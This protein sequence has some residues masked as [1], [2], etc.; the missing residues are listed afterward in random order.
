MAPSPEAAKAATKNTVRQR[1]K[2][3]IAASLA[4][5]AAWVLS[6]PKPLMA[7]NWPN[8]PADATRGAQIFNIGGCASCHME[9]GAKGAARLVLGGGQAFKTP[10]GTFVAP[11]ISPSSQGIG[12]WSTLEFANALTRGISPEGSHYYPAFPY[13]T[14]ARM[15][16]QD[17]VD[18]KAYLGTLPASNRASQPHNIPF[19]FN[20]RRSLGFWK[21]LYLND[22]PIATSPEPRGQ[23]LVEA[24]GHCAE[25]HTPRTLLGGL[26][27]ARWMAGAPNP[28]GK[29]RIP[30]LTPGGATASWSVDDIAYYLE[31]GFTPDYDTAGSTMVEVVENLSQASSEDRL[32]IARYLKAL[33]ALPNAPK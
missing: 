29:G 28:E 24:L 8:L 15:A 27:T 19:P 26:D 14:Y 30:N 25:C 16:P 2:A 21:L 13:A 31:S 11:N 20:I 22:K 7:E 6:A 3:L 33:P 23:Y 18:L 10:F 12:G 1:T 9:K 5:L 32:A 4:G 17:V